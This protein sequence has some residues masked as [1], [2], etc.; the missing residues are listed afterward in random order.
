MRTDNSFRT[1]LS[2]LRNLLVIIFIT[3][4]F[5]L[6]VTATAIQD[7]GC[8][9]LSI[10]PQSTSSLEAI[11]VKREIPF[12][13]EL[14]YFDLKGVVNRSTYTQIIITSIKRDNNEIIRIIETTNQS[15]C[16]GICHVIITGVLTSDDIYDKHIAVA[17]SIVS[18]DPKTELSYIV[19]KENLASYSIYSKY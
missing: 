3:F 17:M 2:Y 5:I 13:I 7:P 14:L 19:C 4:L 9:V 8:K 15:R 12:I 18:T 1:I 11:D 10:K 6:L 16:F